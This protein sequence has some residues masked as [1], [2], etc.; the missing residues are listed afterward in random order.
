MGFVRGRRPNITHAP[1]ADTGGR[2]GLI[3]PGRSI[4]FFVSLRAKPKLFGDDWLRLG[5]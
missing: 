3:M 4:A 5:E 1:P 2:D